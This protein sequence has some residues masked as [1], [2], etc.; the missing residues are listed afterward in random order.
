MRLL[1]GELEPAEAA[2]VEA[3]T[4]ECAECARDLAVYRLMSGQLGG[5]VDTRLPRTTVWPGV[6]RRLARSLGW[7]L[8]VAGVAVWLAWGLYAWLLSPEHLWLKLAEGAVFIGLALVLG[9][10]L[11]E[12]YVSWR[13]DPYRHIQ[14]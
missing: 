14:R 2:R 7:T 12:H 8:F 13:T 1:D 5:E 9:S 11:R 3:H 6:R 10:V 4:R